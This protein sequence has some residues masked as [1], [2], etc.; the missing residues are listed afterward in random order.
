VKRFGHSESLG[1]AAGR[2]AF[3]NHAGRLPT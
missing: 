2:D 1:K 3:T